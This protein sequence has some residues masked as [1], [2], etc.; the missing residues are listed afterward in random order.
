[1]SKSFWRK[2]HRQREIVDQHLV[3]SATIDKPQRRLAI[4]AVR[5]P[6]PKV[7]EAA[8]ALDADSIKD[9]IKPG[10]LGLGATN[11]TSR[12]LIVEGKR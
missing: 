7:D 12:G 8:A 9:A 3:Y 1:M 6:G 2:G 11:V 10:T 4:G 5:L